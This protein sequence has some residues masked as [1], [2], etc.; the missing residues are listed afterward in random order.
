MMGAAISTA[1]PAACCL[2]RLRSLGRRGLNEC[3][4]AG[5]VH[6]PTPDADHTGLQVADCRLQNLEGVSVPGTGTLAS[7]MSC[8]RP[9]TPTHHHARVDAMARKT[10]RLTSQRPFHLVGA[11]FRTLE[12]EA[13]SAFEMH[14]ARCS[15]SPTPS[16]LQPIIPSF[17]QSIAD[18]CCAHPRR[19]SPISPGSPPSPRQCLSDVLFGLPKALVCPDAQ[20]PARCRTVKDSPRWPDSVPT[21]SAEQ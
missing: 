6:P 5:A 4:P 2:P 17:P 8:F 13:V 9:H 7:V 3:F 16:L 1:R 11:L 21:P 12:Q 19:F 18:V 20:P 14:R 10:A 15:V